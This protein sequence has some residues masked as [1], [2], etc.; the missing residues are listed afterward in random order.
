MNKDSEKRKMG[1]WEETSSDGS[2]MKKPKQKKKKKNAMGAFKQWQDQYHK[3][4]PVDKDKF[5]EVELWTDTKWEA[6]K[7]N[8]QQEIP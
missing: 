8:V 1:R 7:E 5:P 4:N 2:E 6:C 3:D